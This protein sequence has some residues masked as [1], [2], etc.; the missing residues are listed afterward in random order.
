MT[1][2]ELRA[3]CVRDYPMPGVPELAREMVWRLAWE[4]GHAW[5]ESEVRF[6]YNELRDLAVAAATPDTP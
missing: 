6:W 3:D 4:H 2:E 1:K 5:G